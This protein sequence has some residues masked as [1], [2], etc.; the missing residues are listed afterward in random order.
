M[1]NLYYNNFL[2]KYF[3]WGRGSIEE[4]EASVLKVV[5]A[6]PTGLEFFKNIY[7]F[8]NIYKFIL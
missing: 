8:I 7:Y 4:R 6:S 1:L 5:G 3:R 2:D